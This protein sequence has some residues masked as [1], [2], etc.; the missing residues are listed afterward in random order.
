L[1]VLTAQAVAKYMPT[2]EPML[3][4]TVYEMVLQDFLQNNHE[5]LYLFSF[6][7]VAKKSSSPYVAGHWLMIF[8]HLADSGQ[9]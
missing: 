6:L 1:V 5:V 3:D 8:G 4:T 9:N 7:F 2:A